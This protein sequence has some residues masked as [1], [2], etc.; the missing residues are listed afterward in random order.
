M[1]GSGNLS[2]GFTVGSTYNGSTQILNGTVVYLGNN[3][4]S[5]GTAVVIN[6]GAL[7]IGNRTD[8]VGSVTLTNGSILGTTGVLTVNAAGGGIYDMRNGTVSAILAGTAN[9]TKTTNGTLILSGNNTF[10]GATTLSAGNISISNVGAFGSTSGVSMADGTTLLYTGGAG[11]LGANITIASGIGTLRNTGGSTLNLS[12]TLTKNGTVLTFGQGA[13][14]VTGSIAGS[15]ANS[16]LVVEGATLVLNAANTYNG[17]TIIRN[18]GS[19]TANV[20]NALPTANG[21]SALVLD[22]SGTGGSVLVLGAS[23]SIA[24]LTGAASSNVTL[25]ANTLT[26]GTASVNTTF[27]GRISGAG[28]LVKDGDSIQILS[29]NNTY[30]GTTTINNGTLHA[31]APGALGATSSVTVNNGGSLLI[32]ASG[33]VADNAAI[34]LGSGTLAGGL[35]LSGNTGEAM[36]ALTLTSNSVIDMGSGAAWLSFDS[37]TAILTS[38]TQLQIWN[39]TPG[40]DAV[41]FRSSANIQSSLAFISFY[42]GAGTGTFF[43][44]LNTASFSPPELYPTPVPEAETWV[45]AAALL[46]G[47]GFAWVK[48]RGRW[49]KDNNARRV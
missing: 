6:G 22:D 28:N 42:S 17:P 39:Y 34:L 15:N 31:N 24:S 48:R 32:G 30:S 43:N 49:M 25:G 2:L 1:N 40:L 46:A 8:T 35:A 36:G 29:G 4:L 7:N 14:N 20:S 27:A 47:A 23:Q 38:T 9:L 33:S 19:L 44:A 18:G 21:R 11:T 10:S 5:D 3:A 26:I 41:Y 13:F 12:G 37:L 45:A 16:D